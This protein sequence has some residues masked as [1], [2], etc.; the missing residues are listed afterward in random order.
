MEKIIIDIEAKTD[1]AAKGLDK[2]AKE[3]QEVF[4]TNKVS[5]FNY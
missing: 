5:S 1:K 2:V 4:E 3:V